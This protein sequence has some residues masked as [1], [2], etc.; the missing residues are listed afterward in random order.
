VS[1][2]LENRFELTYSSLSNFGEQL[3]RKIIYKI[4]FKFPAY[5]GL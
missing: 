1:D 5:I 4:T 3:F 2:V